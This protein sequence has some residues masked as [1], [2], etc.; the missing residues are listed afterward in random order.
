MIL[1]GLGRAEGV[2]QPAHRDR[3]IAVE[4]D[5]VVRPAERR[6][7]REPGASELTRSRQVDGSIGGKAPQEAIERCGTYVVQRA[8]HGDPPQ[9]F[10]VQDI[11]VMCPA[12]VHRELREGVRPAADD[13][14]G[15]VRRPLVAKVRPELFPSTL[16]HEVPSTITRTPPVR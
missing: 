6:Q 13:D 15:V 10:T 11:G 1:I 14:N 12:G 5:R 2:E 9:R 8:I 3:I 4:P 7:Q 16:G